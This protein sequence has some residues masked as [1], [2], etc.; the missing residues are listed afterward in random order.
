MT[1]SS[2]NYFSDRCYST[3]LVGDCAAVPARGRYPGDRGLDDTTA[4]ISR[5]SSAKTVLKACCLGGSE[6]RH[7]QNPAVSGIKC[8][9]SAPKY[10]IVKCQ[11]AA[12]STL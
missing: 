7:P 4:P 3:L 11:G 2:Y 10:R 12:R 1:R 8:E 5:R 9:C 6:P